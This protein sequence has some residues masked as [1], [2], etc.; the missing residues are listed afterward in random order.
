MRIGI[1]IQTATTE[2]PRGIGF[3]THNLV[4]ELIDLDAEN[5]YFLYY[6]AP[7]LN[8]M[9]V[10][11]FGSQHGNVHLRPVRFPQRWA[12]SRP[13]LW[14]DY[15]LPL[16]V[17]RDRL[18]VYHCPSHFLPALRGTG[19]VITIHDVAFFKADNLY[20]SAMTDS[21]RHWTKSSLGRADR[22]IALSH[23][24]A[25][26]LEE[27]GVERDRIRTIYGG[28]NLVG[29]E[30]IGIDKL[31]EVRRRYCLPAKYVLYVGTL[32]PRKN[33][34]FLLRA[35]A[36]YR[37]HDRECKLVLVGLLDSAADEIRSLI[38]ELNLERDVIITGYVESWEL[39]LIY[40]SAEVFVLPSSYEGFGM[41]VVE[42]MAYGVPVVAADTSCLHEV[43]GDA[44]VLVPANDISALVT[45]LSSI[46]G[47]AEYRASMI[48]RGKLRS[49]QFSWRECARKTLDVYRESVGICA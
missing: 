37:K 4:R 22:V 16:Q 41:T 10:P 1:Y 9:P 20:R 18:D 19:L 26:D 44:G 30:E 43:L 21:L 13:R 25:A 27:L 23:N 42:A 35:F 15:W 46:M 8:G 33:I 34:G 47:D 29:E 11:P 7:L 32:H 2:Q 6:P 3:H 36:E 49:E 39:P 24:T 38:Q 12:G 28:G 14:W 5:E 48:Q 17:R 40:K 45:A 31:D